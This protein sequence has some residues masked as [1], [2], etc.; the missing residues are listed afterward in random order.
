MLPWYSTPLDTR[1]SKDSVE[2]LVSPPIKTVTGV[3][4]TVKFFFTRYSLNRW[5][6]S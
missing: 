1:L 4:Y 3:S 6:A 2:G 5:T